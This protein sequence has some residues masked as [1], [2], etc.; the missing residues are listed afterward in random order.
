M[1]PSF[2]P[3]AIGAVA[4][5]AGLRALCRPS[6]CAVTSV[7][8]RPNRVSTMCR[9]SAASKAS[10]TTADPL[11]RTIRVTMTSDSTASISTAAAV[12]VTVNEDVAITTRARMKTKWKQQ[13]RRVAEAANLVPT[14]L[15]RVRLLTTDW[16]VG[17]ASLLS[18]LSFLVS[19]ATGHFKVVSKSLKCAT[20]GV[21]NTDVS[22]TTISS[23]SDATT[24]HQHHHHH[25]HPTVEEGSSQPAAVCNSTSS[26]TTTAK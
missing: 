8:A 20:R 24:E 4:S 22:V 2:V 15:V 14:P 1:T 17:A 13:Q 6:G 7:S 3:S 21:R 12:R 9:A 16:R 19:S 25:P 18:V 23:S 10:F 26:S 5:R 11:R